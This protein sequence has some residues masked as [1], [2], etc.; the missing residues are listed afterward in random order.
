M[1]AESRSTTVMAFALA[2]LVLTLLVLQG[3]MAS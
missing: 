3:P 1:K 2:L